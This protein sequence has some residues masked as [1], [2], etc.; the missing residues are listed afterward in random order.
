MN[1]PHATG[2]GPSDPGTCPR[3]ESPVAA[4]SIGPTVFVGCGKITR[5]ELG[6]RSGFEATGGTFGNY[7]GS[8]RRNGLADVD[9]D[10]VSV[11]EALFLGSDR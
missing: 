10:H 11:S 3:C 5:E 7:L 1:A 6:A 8:L 2:G 4:T 9:G